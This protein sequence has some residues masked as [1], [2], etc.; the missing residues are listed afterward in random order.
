MKTSAPYYDSTTSPDATLYVAND[1]QV[2]SQTVT[3]YDDLGRATTRSLYSL[4]TLQW[5]TTTTYLGMNQVD[6]TPPSGGAA[7][8]TI[9]NVLG[10]ETQSWVY[11]D[12]S[13]TPT[14]QASDAVVTK[15]GYNTSG[16]QTSVTDANGN[17]WSYA[18]NLLG[19]QTSVTD[20]GTGTAGASGQAGTTKYTYDPDGNVMSVTDPMNNVITYAYD[21]LNRKTAEYNDT[22]GTPVQVA[23]W[24]YD[25]LAKGHLT[26]ST[27]YD[28]SGQAYTEA[29]TGLNTA[30]EPTGTS[31]TVPS[32]AGAL[33][34]S[35]A[36]GSVTQYTT[37]I[38]YDPLT[39]LPEYT[40]YTDDGNLPAEVVSYT[41]DLEGLLTQYGSGTP[42]LDNTTFTPQGQ[43]TRPRSARTASS[44][45]QDYSYDAGSD[46]QLS[47][48][49]NL[50]TLSQPADVTNSYAYDPSGNI[51]SVSDQQDATAGQPDQ[52]QCFKYNNLDEL[53]QAW[54]DSGTTT[55]QPAPEVGGIGGCTD[56]SPAAA[57]IGGVQP[58]WQQYS[59]DALGDRT[60]E[61]SHD[62]ASVSQ[63]TTANE[64]TQQIAF[65]GAT[66]TT[67]PYTQATGAEGQPDAAQAIAV[68]GPGGTAA[69]TDTYNADGELANSATTTTG[70]TPRSLRRGHRSSTTP[71]A[72]SPRHDLGGHD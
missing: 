3:G 71:R 42:Y 5:K 19:Q 25:T 15:Y 4:G 32:D 30:Y 66:T 26:S 63:D 67:T 24:K 33:A 69:T 51:T 59:Y 68:T 64:T 34:S 56:T 35:T 21:A 45:V 13:A 54:T 48:I 9:G 46:R 72:R 58:Y 52:L 62:T 43:V 8:T 61:V 16:Q 53:T 14:D 23:S 65:T 31:M 44:S 47:S 11:D 28:S 39:G 38:A 36:S 10:Q 27:A 40:A 1:N 29:I 55:T 17:T 2:P 20:P 37:Q 7:T 50:Q 60:Q 22:T 70:A 49:T 18:Y 12:R 6:T 57:S 41:Y